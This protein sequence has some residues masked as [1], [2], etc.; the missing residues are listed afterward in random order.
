MLVSFLAADK[1]FIDL[2]KSTQFAA[3][4]GCAASLTKTLKHEPCRLLSNSNLFGKLHRTDA[5]PRR[6]HQVH[7]VN[8]LVQ[9]DRKSTR[10][11]SSHRC[12][13]YAVFCLKKK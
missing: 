9:G 1:A 10:L 7:R 8:P 2:N 4:S 5:L 13:S 3:A 12:I 11:N 6:D